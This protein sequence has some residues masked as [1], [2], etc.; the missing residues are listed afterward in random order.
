M[1]VVW[2]VFA[3]H[4]S[5]PHPP[6]KILMPKF[7][8]LTNKKS[9]FLYLFERINHTKKALPKISY[10]YLKKHFLNKIPFF[11][12]SGITHAYLLK[13]SITYNQS[14][15]I[16]L[17]IAYPQDQW[18]KNYIWTMSTYFYIFKFFNNRFK[19]FFS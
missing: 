12:F 14:R 13:I 5:L 2:N 9:N 19:W 8:M 15:N 7:L 11:S 17:L 10:M 16:Y 3:R 1:K 4:T 18:P 6:K